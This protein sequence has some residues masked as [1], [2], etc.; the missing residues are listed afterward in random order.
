M[1]KLY[2]D[3]GKLSKSKKIIYQ[4]LSKYDLIIFDLDDTIFPL[5]YYDL[6][7]F[8][9]ICIN[10]SKR[11]NLNIKKLLY[12]LIKYKF[13]KKTKKK[14]FKIFIKEFNL[15]NKINEKELVDTYQNSLLNKKLNFP[16]LINVIKKL[17]KNKKKIMLVTEGHYNRQKNKIK[18]TGISSLLDYQIILD[19]KYNRK[20]KP[21]TLGLKKFKDIF[22][23]NKVIYI[24]N[25][26]KD[27]RLS[28]AINVKFYHF[29]ITKFLKY[30]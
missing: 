6:L 30:I 15:N 28:S 16:S 9:K 5:Y 21:S 14:L 20:F 13:V 8:K 1:V 17:K 10:I 24:G 2:L 4:V 22:K 19:G 18:S 7:I 23:N 29:D 25:S 3:T 26:I 11:F 12:F 27:R